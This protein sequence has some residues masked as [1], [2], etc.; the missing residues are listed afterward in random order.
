MWDPAMWEVKA[1]DVKRS[2]THPLPLL[3]PRCCCMRKVYCSLRSALDS[4]F[5]I[6][7]G[8]NLF[9]PFR[10]RSISHIDG[11]HHGGH[12]GR[13]CVPRRAHLSPRDHTC[14]PSPHIPPKLTLPRPHC[15]SI[16]RHLCALRATYLAS[17]CHALCH[18]CDDAQ[19]VSMRTRL[20]H[21]S[22]RDS[23]GTWQHPRYGTAGPYHCNRG[24]CRSPVEARVGVRGVC[25]CGLEA[26]STDTLC[27]VRVCM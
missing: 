25:T 26:T 2:P 19:R 4:A 20:I 3:C 15:P 11:G 14:I 16:S 10:I 9:I 1:L 22:P 6:G 24:C 5:K 8:L 13:W 23:S 27:C 17:Y 12:P 18:Y 21:R 7:F